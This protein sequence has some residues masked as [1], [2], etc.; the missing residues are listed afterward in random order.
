[1]RPVRQ[2]GRCGAH[3]REAA[4]DEVGYV[5]PVALDRRELA[6]QDFQDER[7]LGAHSTRHVQAQG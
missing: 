4:L 2:G 5:R 3:L 6:A 1:M 7:A